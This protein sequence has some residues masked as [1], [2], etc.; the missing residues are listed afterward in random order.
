MLYVTSL[1]FL[2]G[3]AE[4]GEPRQDAEVVPVARW[5][6]E[7]ELKGDVANE[8]SLSSQVPIRSWKFIVLHHSATQ[9]GSLESIDEIHRQR[10][11]SSGRNWKGI[12][13]HFIIG[14]GHGMED[15]ELRATFRW[16]DQLSGAHA[17]IRSYNDYG[18]GIC[19]IGNFEKSGPTSAQMKTATQLVAHLKDE[20]GILPEQVVK[21][22]DLKATACPGRLFPIEKIAQS[23]DAG[24]QPG[25]DVTRSRFSS[26][27]SAHMEGI[28][29]VVSA[30][31]FRPRSQQDSAGASSAG[32]E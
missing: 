11:D 10:K 7:K 5:T 3:C 4:S 23:S 29:N 30:Q 28:K 24:L 16:N 12:G 27:K 2:C 8:V 14:N 13:Y 1:V 21:H 17:G 32:R 19:L 9:S 6:P 31:R 15:G 26:E 18:I 22:G 20:F 25:S